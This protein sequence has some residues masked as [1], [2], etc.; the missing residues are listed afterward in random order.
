MADNQKVKYNL[1]WPY[2]NVL[3]NVIHS[4]NI[5]DTVSFYKNE[6]KNVSRT[7]NFADLGLPQNLFHQKLRETPL[8]VSSHVL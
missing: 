7:I 2:Y 6:Y 8:R 1:E 3:K 4:C 5:S